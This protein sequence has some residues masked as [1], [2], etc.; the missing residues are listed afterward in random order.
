MAVTASAGLAQ[1]RV[2]CQPKFMVIST[3]DELI[4]PGRHIEE[5]QVRRSNAY[6]IIGA[7][8]NR[9]FEEVDDDHLRDDERLLQE[10]LARH[11]S[12]HDVLILSGGVSHGKFDLVPRVLKKLAVREIVYQV[13]QRPGMPMWF[14]IGPTGQAVFGLPGNPVATLVC[15]IRYVIPAMTVAMGAPC[16]PPQ[17]VA[18]GRPVTFNKGVTYF[19][20]ASLHYDEHGRRIALPR[21]PNGPGD[22]LSLTITNGFVEL[23]PRAEDFPEG[24]VADFYKW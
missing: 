18:L 24:F 3:G 8:R 15:L 12:C 5:H 9:G 16:E 1:V 10:C 20:P 4:E 7:L 14:G 21:P 13:A 23:P 6:A 11:L 22:F 2:S 17:T 19:L